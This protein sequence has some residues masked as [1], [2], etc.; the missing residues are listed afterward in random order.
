MSFYQKYLKYKNKYLKL[1]T[2]QSGGAAASAAD[3]V[4]KAEIKLEPNLERIYKII[5]SDEEMQF[6]IQRNDDLWTNEDEKEKDKK[7]ENR[8]YTFTF[9]KDYLDH[10]FKGNISDDDMR[11][12]LNFHLRPLLDF[13][14]G[15][16]KGGLTNGHI[17]AMKEFYIQEQKKRQQ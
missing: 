5:T 3:D 2:I 7:W 13:V 4:E 10:G 15:S 8:W 12:V 11:Q 9:M 14:S 1:M 16:F 6:L 17:K